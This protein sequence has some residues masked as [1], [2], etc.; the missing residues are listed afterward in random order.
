MKIIQAIISGVDKVQD[1]VHIV[2]ALLAGLDTFTS[3]LKKFKTPE[4][5]Q[6]MKS[7]SSTVL[8][9]VLI[10]FS[11]F[12]LIYLFFWEQI[13]EYFIKEFFQTMTNKGYVNQL[14]VELSKDPNSFLGK[15]Q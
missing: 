14:L 11:V 15:K 10:I 5:E 4:K 2:R 1:I 8:W 7:I 6:K 12:T 13:K 3:E 9:S